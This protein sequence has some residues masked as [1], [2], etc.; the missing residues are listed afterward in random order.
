MARGKPGFASTVERFR[1]V[2]EVLVW[3]ANGEELTIFPAADNDQIL[4]YCR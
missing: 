1:F 3:H 4:S 2:N